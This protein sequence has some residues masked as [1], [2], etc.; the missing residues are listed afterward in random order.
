MTR[1]IYYRYRL[2]LFFWGPNEEELQ[3]IAER[4]LKRHFPNLV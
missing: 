1:F 3:E 2:R 4:T